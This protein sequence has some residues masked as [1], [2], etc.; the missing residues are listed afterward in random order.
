MHYITGASQEKAEKKV[1]TPEVIH[2]RIEKAQ[3]RLIERRMDD[4]T[5]EDR[6][7]ST[8]SFLASSQSTKECCCVGVVSLA[9][10]DRYDSVDKK[11]IPIPLLKVNRQRLENLG[12]VISEDA[13]WAIYRESV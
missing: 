4:L 3:W 6:V 11:S 1:L 12:F 13:L 5:A 9:Y 8:S 10:G 2:Q 7:D